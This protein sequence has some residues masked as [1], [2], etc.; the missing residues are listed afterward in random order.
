MAM[1]PKPSHSEPSGAR[2]DS[3]SYYSNLA[4]NKRGSVISDYI[5]RFR[6]AP[7]TRRSQRMRV[8]VSARAAFAD[9]EHA[10]TKNSPGNIEG[11]ND[12]N[13]N[14]DVD[15]EDCDDQYWTTSTNTP[16]TLPTFNKSLSQSISTIASIGTKDFASSI[17]SVGED[18]YGGDTVDTGNNNSDTFDDENSQDSRQP[19]PPPPPLPPPSPT[20]HTTTS[21]TTINSNSSKLDTHAE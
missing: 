8:G 19:T 4:A 15:S 20:A 7:P 5:K 21:T 10:N 2:D 12:S 17:D 16:Q 3:G 14:D 1:K 11:E 18:F 9:S 13:N 6:T